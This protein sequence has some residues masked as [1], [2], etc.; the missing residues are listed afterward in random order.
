MGK[1]GEDQIVWSLLQLWSTNQLK[2]IPVGR[3]PRLNIEVEGI[4]NYAYFE[5]IEIVDE[6]NWYPS[7]VGID[8]ATENHTIF[9]FKKRIL[10]VKY[11]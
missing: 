2:V 10:S 5:V 9:K 1:Y 6:I 8:Q 3:L 11:S 4:W 7:L